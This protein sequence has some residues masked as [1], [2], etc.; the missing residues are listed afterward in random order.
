MM[1]QIKYIKPFL[2]FIPALIL[3]L[4]VVPLIS[5][6][7]VAPD[8]ITIVLV[9]AVLLNGQF[10]GTAAGFVFGFIF[11]LVSGGVLGSAMFSKTLAGF[12]TGY[13]Y[14]ENKI[15]YYTKTYWFSVIILI[16]AMVDSIIYTALSSSA[17]KSFLMMLFWGG[18]LPGIYSAVVS[19][20]FVIIKRKNEIE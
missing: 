2:F 17:Q 14:N 13:F 1:T 12:I 10:Y 19:F 20:P 8:L 11:D 4:T 3:Q 6:E 16:I 9:Y 15:E 18:I 7:S 5:I